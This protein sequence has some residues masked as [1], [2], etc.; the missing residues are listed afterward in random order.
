MAMGGGL[1]LSG[2]ID[3]LTGMVKEAATGKVGSF[4]LNGLQE[5]GKRSVAGAGGGRAAQEQVADEIRRAAEGS[6]GV[7][8][9]AIGGEF[10]AVV[11]VVLVVVAVVLVWKAVK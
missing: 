2:T 10:S 7:I 3:W 8:Q 4:T 6:A 11:Q 5:A 1:S 9:R